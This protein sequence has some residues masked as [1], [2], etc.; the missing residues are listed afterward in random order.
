MFTFHPIQKYKKWHPGLFDELALLLDPSK[1]ESCAVEKLMQDKVYFLFEVNDAPENH[2]WL[3]SMLIL[4]NRHAVIDF[5]GLHK[6]FWRGH[7]FGPN[8]YTLDGWRHIQINYNVSNLVSSAETQP[9]YHWQDIDWMIS[10]PDNIGHVL[11]SLS[12]NNT[13]VPLYA[14]QTWVKDLPNPA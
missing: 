4:T 6:Y 1:F 9:M 2:N 10:G 13:K 11:W 5:F 12:I 3:G 7:S 8:R 14:A